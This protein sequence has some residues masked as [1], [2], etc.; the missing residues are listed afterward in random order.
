MEIKVSCHLIVDS[1]ILQKVLLFPYLHINQRHKGEATLHVLP[2]S[3]SGL[4][5]SNV[6]VRLTELGWYL[7]WDVPT[8][9]PLWTNY[10]HLLVKHLLLKVIFNS[11]Y[12]VKKVSF[13][14]TFFSHT[15]LYFFKKSATAKDN[16]NTILRRWSFPH[17]SIFFP[18][19]SCLHHP[20]STLVCIS[21]IKFDNTWL[22]SLLRSLSAVASLSLSFRSWIRIP[23]ILPMLDLVTYPYLTLPYNQW[24]WKIHPS[25]PVSSL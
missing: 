20:F 2:A 18:K 9:V 23:C 21:K 12:H 16:H 11:A 5:L 6:P 25:L 19:Q 24:I 17:H 10:N 13:F 22:P 8:I 3:I 7:T 1:L 14:G 4:H 15:D